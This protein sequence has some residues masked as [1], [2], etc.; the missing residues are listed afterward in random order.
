MPAAKTD[1]KKL[2]RQ[3]SKAG[4]KYSDKSP[5]QPELTPI[6]EAIKKLLLPYK[7]GTMK[8]ISSPGQVVLISKKPVEILGRK[9]NELWFASALVQK[10]YVGFYYMPVYGDSR[11]K[12]LIKPELLKCLKGKSCFHIKRYDA[13]ILSQIQDALG[14]GYTLWRKMGWL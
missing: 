12:Q 14:V 1:S 7:K 4:V 11:V 6:F 5:G 9:K 3:K 13:E 2:S 10:G 8:L